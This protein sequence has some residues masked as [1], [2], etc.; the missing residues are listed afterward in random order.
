M[1]MT[2][3][4]K[5]GTVIGIDLGTTTTEAAVF[6]DGKAEMILNFDG[7]IITPSVIGLDDS[8]NFVIG[9]KARAQYIMAPE[10]T[11]IEVKRKMGSGERIRLGRQ[12]FTPVELSSMLLGYVKRYASQYLNEE[13]TRAVISVPAY[14]DDIQRQAVVEAGQEAGLTVERIINEPTAA[15][16]SYG[17]SHMEDE[18]YLLV[19]DLG[20]GTFDVT[21]LEMFGGVLEVKASSG[22]NA[23][24]GKDFDERLI[25]WLRE[26]FEKGHGISLEGN[27]FALA[28][29]KEQAEQC[30]IGLSSQEEVKVAIPLLA[31]KDGIP[32]GLD[33]TVTRSQFEEMIRDLIEKTHDP[34]QT[35]LNDGGVT[36]EQLAMV[37][38]VGGS[39][40]IPMVSRD[41]R[42]FLGAE[43]KAEVHPD[44]SVA[45]GAAIQA[46]IIGGTIDSEEG[47]V[48]TDVNPYTLGIRAMREYNDDYMSVVIPRNVTIPVRRH[49]I[50]S[51]SWDNQ[52]EAEIQVYQGESRTA[53]RNHRLG[54]FRISGIPD[55][56]AGKEK[57]DVSLS[58]D[59]NGILQV[60][61]TIVSTGEEASVR[62]DMMEAGTKQQADVSKWRDAP[63]AGDY[64]SILRR[65][66]KLIKSAK[67]ERG[68]EDKEE[69][70]RELEDLVYQL[71]M[72]VLEDDLEEAD[73]LE[74]DIRDLIEEE[75]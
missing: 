45:E 54:N 60:S 10:R 7:K 26:C 20:G 1:G 17:I 4:N 35:V 59:Q 11:A 50:Y 53:S 25:G 18:N 55:G 62:I 19:Y 31:E 37:L 66:E 6:R 29:L 40:R 24:G 22:N 3:E 64:R 58:Y 43:P 21:L 75:W 67:A 8:G 52:N 12:S 14:F 68:N 47:L 28:R 69:R 71:K 48:V 27:A 49:E 13:I 63:S 2:G 32:L 42:E 5:N 74:E 41:I 51:T 61:A 16:L 39:T 23:L 65:A 72:A 56:P 9:E 46:G 33:I 36:G 38:L 34:I 44:Y 15:S 70:I 30:K 57:I 73:Y